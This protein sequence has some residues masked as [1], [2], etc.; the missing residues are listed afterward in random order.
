MFV[1][2]VFTLFVITV[3]GLE[4]ATSCVRDQDATTVLARHI[5]ET[6]SL[7]WAQF[8]L[9]WFISLP[10]LTEFSDCSAPFRKNSNVSSVYGNWIV[11]TIIGG[12]DTRTL[13]ATNE[14]IS[15]FFT[16]RQWGPQTLLSLYGFPH[17][18]VPGP[19]IEIFTTWYFLIHM[20]IFMFYYYGQQF[21]I[22]N[23]KYQCILNIDQISL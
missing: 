3:K 21:D 7:N 12:G 17:P 22:S 9:Q 2:T 10:G 5:W 16:Q 14:F 4:P 20:E 13:T 1:I 8:M 6:G 18:I 19:L 23:F 11:S 15:T